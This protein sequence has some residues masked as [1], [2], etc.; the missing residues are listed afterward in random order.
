MGRILGIDYGLKRTGLAVTDP[1]QIIVQGLETQKTADLLSFLKLY[2]A[3]E[4]VDG[5]VV[6]YPFLEGE[7]GDR[8]FKLK[9]DAFISVLKKDFPKIELKLHDER[10]SS[11]RAREIIYQSGVKKSK[12][13]SKELLDK[14]SAIVILQEY[15][16]HI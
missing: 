2:A 3:K 16:G 11:M 9:L 12:R 1:L 7:W 6:G 13:H 10:F 5:F 4:P 15:L 14:T 8:N